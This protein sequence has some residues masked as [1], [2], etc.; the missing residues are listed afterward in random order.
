MA[1]KLGLWSKSRDG[2]RDRELALGLR[3][4]VA[5]RVAVVFDEG[6]LV[7]DAATIVSSAISAFFSFARSVGLATATSV[8]FFW[9]LALLLLLLRREFS[10]ISA[11]GL[12]RCGDFSAFL[13]ELRLSDGVGPAVFCPAPAFSLPAAMATLAGEL[14]RGDAHPFPATTAGDGARPFS[15]AGTETIFPGCCLAAPELAAPAEG[16]PPSPR[17]PGDRLDLLLP[18]PVLS[19]LPDRFLCGEL[20]WG[21]GLDTGTPCPSQSQ[22]SSAP[23]PL[24]S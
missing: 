9:G 2:L 14:D 5:V 21:D 13:D 11:M 16:A 19:R 22:S 12:R 3:F 18:P 10:S 15:L 4:S 7:S 6:A 1:L 24:L 20:R 23:P 17:R 8:D